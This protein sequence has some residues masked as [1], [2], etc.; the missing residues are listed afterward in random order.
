MAK[1]ILAASVLGLNAEL[2]EVE[3]ESVNGELGFIAIVGLPDTAI[4]E[5]RERVR[6]AIKNSGLNFPVRKVVINLAPANLKKYGPSYDLPIAVSILSLKYN[7]KVDFSRMLFVGELSLNGEL[8]P[9][10]GILPIAL[11]AQE[12]G[13]KTIYVPQKNAAE[14]K[15]GGKLEVIPVAN[16]RDLYLHLKQEVLI[17]P[18]AEH[19]FNFSNV[20]TNFDMADVRGQEQVKRA[21]E[22]AASGAHN[23]LLYGPPGSGKT[24]LAKSLASILPD[25]NLPEALEVT[26]IYS[27]AGELKN[28]EALIT[29][30]PFRSPHHT[31]SAPALVGGGSWPRPGEI[32]LAHRGVLFL[33]EFA[34]FPRNILENLRQP[35]EDGI[36]S[37][38]RASG[39]LKFPA[40]FILIAA[41][42]PCPCGYFKDKDRNCVCSERQIINYRKKIS[43]PILDRIDLHIEVPRVEFDKLSA[44]ASGEN[45]ASVKKRVEAARARQLVRFSDKICFSNAEMDT[46]TTDKHCQI[47]KAG[48]QLLA[49]A[50]DKLK[51]SAR[52]YFRILK[53][54][55]TIADLENEEKIASKHLA[56]ALQYRP[57]LEI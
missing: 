9:I 16:L 50:M 12:L 25:L 20:A 1:K 36:I 28:N 57:R 52:S 26:K 30:R 6:T 7:L 23:V 55:R 8:R 41:M 14:A 43:G 40:K 54:A 39:R 33:D 4:S 27:V 21:L 47:D 2:V 18:Q 42:N 38:S 29:S 37:I 32:S 53:L 15:L 45:S 51:L 19:N 56:E 44:G 11:L 24:L 17:P 31:S 49:Q 46:R 13:L 34:E 5:S 3:A 35:L 48:R 10:N 22:I